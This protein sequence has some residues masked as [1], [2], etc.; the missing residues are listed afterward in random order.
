M[1]G[2]GL[3]RLAGRWGARALLAVVAVVATGVAVPTALAAPAAS[4]TMKRANPF[5]VHGGVDPY[6]M[7]GET[8]AKESGDNTY[9]L[10]KKSL[11]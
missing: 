2:A 3:E 11:R 1:I 5:G 10:K 8:F 7:S 4:I 6:T 9:S